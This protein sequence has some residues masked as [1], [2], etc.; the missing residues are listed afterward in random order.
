[1]ASVGHAR[2]GYTRRQPTTIRCSCLSRGVVTASSR[3]A[4][5]THRTTSSSSGRRLPWHCGTEQRSK[6]AVQRESMRCGRSHHRTSLLHVFH[7]VSRRL[8]RATAL[9]HVR[10]R[11]R[12]CCRRDRFHSAR[13]TSDCQ[14][15]ARSSAISPYYINEQALFF[16]ERLA[17]N[18]GY[19]ADRSSANAIARPF[20]PEG[21]AMYR[22][23][24]RSR[25]RLMNQIR[26]AKGQSGNPHAVRRSRHPVRRRW[27]HW[28]GTAQSSQPACLEIRH[29]AGNRTSWNSVFDASFFGSRLALEGTRYQRRITTA[30]ELPLPPSSGLG[31][32]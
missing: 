7:D 8:V 13:R 29:Q 28:A 10:I 31:S 19:R 20:C 12:A 22:L 27:H 16:N 18:G 26:G 4:C 11:G 24:V 2:L 17:L 6:P 21:S 3:K 30:A 23:F 14:T 5:S 25:T 32:Q 1:M 9:E 15:I